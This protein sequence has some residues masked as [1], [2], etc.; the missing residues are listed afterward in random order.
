MTLIH[1]L[2]ISLKEFFE[3]VGL[4][5]GNGYLLVKKDQ[6]TPLVREQRSGMSCQVILSQNVTHCTMEIVHVTMEPGTR[7]KVASSSGYEFKYMLSGTCHFSVNDDLL[8]LE[9]GDSIYFDASVQHV[10]V[11]RTKT[12]I[13]F[14]SIHFILP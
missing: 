9:E 10:P 11:N 14:L 13:M 8:E 2:E 3:D 1:S 4:M 12:R 6:Y 7:G 5:N